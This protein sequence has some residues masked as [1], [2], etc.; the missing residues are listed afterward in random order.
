VVRLAL[1]YVEF[2]HRHQPAL[3]RGR[4][5]LC[6]HTQETADSIL[7]NI[8]EALSEESRGDKRRFFRYAMRSAGEAEKAL[9]AAACLGLLPPPALDQGFRL[10]RDI[11]LD[12]RRLIRWTS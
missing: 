11:R 6:E 5:S 8:G 9:R 3:W 7:L 2:C 10:L 4:P 12:L 1:Q